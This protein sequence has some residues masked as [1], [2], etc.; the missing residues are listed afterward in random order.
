MA[1]K[2]G[3]SF[4]EDGDAVVNNNKKEFVSSLKISLLNS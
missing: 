1:K 3:T 4:M 2:H